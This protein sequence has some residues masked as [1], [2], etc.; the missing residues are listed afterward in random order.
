MEIKM[1]EV[2][3]CLSTAEDEKNYFSGTTSKPPVIDPDE[4]LPPGTYR[5][6]DGE[7]YR[8]LPGLPPP[9]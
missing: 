8:I 6:I 2:Q 3:M 9:Q 4:I 1:I 7:L 5:I